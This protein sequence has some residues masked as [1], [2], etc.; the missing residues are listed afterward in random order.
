MRRI[1]EVAGELEL[2]EPS[3]EPYGHFM[4]KVDPT[5]IG[6]LE[7]RGAVVLVT[8]ITPT[9]KGVG[10]T[11]TMLGLGSGLRR[12]GVSAVSCLRQPSMGPVFGIKGGGA[13]GGKA[14]VEPF[15]DVN[16]GMTGDM[17]AIV[18]A[19]NLLASLVDNHL[20]FGNELGIDTATIAWPRTLDLEDRPLR[21]VRI[22]L[23]KGNSPERPGSFI[24]APASE[25]TGLLGLAA[26][27]E[28]LR[29]R[30]G[31]L[32]VGK[33][34]EG[35]AVTAEQLH[36]AGP[37]AIL[38]R[39]AILPNLLQTPEGAPVLV[40]GGPFGN[41]SYGTTTRAAIQLGRKV[42]DVVLVEAGFGTDLGGEKFVNLVGPLDGFAA[43]AAVLVVSLPVLRA[44][45]GTDAGPGVA[46][47]KPGLDNL[48]QH[49]RNLKTYGLPTIVALNRFPGDTPGEL[50][51]VRDRCATFEVPC[52]DNAAFEKGGA[53][54]VELAG[55][56]WE[57][58][59]KARFALPL[60]QPEMPMR[61]KID[62][63]VRTLYG[64]DGADISEDVE[65]ALEHPLGM[66]DGK[67]PI[68]M[69][70]TQ[71]SLSDDPKKLGRPQGFRVKVREVVS[72]PGAGYVVA[73]LGDILT[74]PGLP[75]QPKSAEMDLRP[76]GSVVGVT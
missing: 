74:M 42:A 60:Y 18:N 67:V 33:D 11:V 22:G 58:T 75:K 66:K 64:G 45:S 23:G 7:R 56:V 73:L 76:D 65:A 46:D 39:K 17:N 4:A 61:E 41:L 43:S 51:A 20:H 21:Q 16:L 37:M 31:R 2:P 49:L 1:Y 40:H 36:A 72:A 70:K 9:S 59:K 48:E 5:Q 35:G 44:H 68:C 8:G 71:L 30:L 19:H 15:L 3:W 29:T 69:A 24:I 62:R 50:Q 28:D 52:I 14:T 13:G 47:L 25:I 54:C 53:G 63:I 55:A 34:T 38:L 32:V 10:K 57:A 6:K 12:I 27:P 26:G